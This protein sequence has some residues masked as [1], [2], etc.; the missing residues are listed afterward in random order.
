MTNVY[1]IK[2]IVYSTVKSF[3][4]KF[5]MNNL[6][7]FLIIGAQKAGTVALKYYLDQ[8]P[9]LRSASKEVSFF[10]NNN[11]YKGYDH[12][13]VFFPLRF[14]KKVKLFEKT[15]EYIFI[16]WTAER[17]YKY[18]KNIKMILILRDPV[19]RAYSEWNHFIKYYNNNEGYDRNKLIDDY[20]SR[21]GLK[22]S[23]KMIDFLTAKSYITFNDYIKEEIET[24]NRNEFRIAP[25]FVR[26]GMYSEQIKRYYKLFPKSQLLIIES[27]ELR[28]N[29]KV[30]LNMITDFLKISR[31]DYDRIDLQDAHKSKYN[32]NKIDN[33]SKMILKI[34]YKP[35]NEDLYALLEKRYDWD[36]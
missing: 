16:P 21:Y 7:D 23:K 1:R 33:E 8:H 30:V 19:D 24:I 10:S 25:N 9:Q 34:F 5:G 35:Y 28:K 27:S 29:K 26:R 18:N 3:L 12:Y 14:S 6:P 22:R 4:I 31:F 2:N 17:I 15:P 13:K 11:Y 36:S 32:D 20:I